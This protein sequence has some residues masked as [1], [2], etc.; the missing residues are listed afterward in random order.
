MSL[1]IARTFIGANAADSFPFVKQVIAEKSALWIRLTGF[2][3]RDDVCC[4]KHCSEVRDDWQPSPTG[5]RP[6][7]PGRTQIDLWF[8]FIRSCR[9]V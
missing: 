9:A 5:E 2:C 6:M 7:L 3:S 4:W 8:V 1:I